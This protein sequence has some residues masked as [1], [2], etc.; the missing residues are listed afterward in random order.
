MPGAPAERTPSGQPPSGNIRQTG[1]VP[2][3]AAELTS[4]SRSATIPDQQVAPDGTIGVPYAGRI[5]AAGRTAEEVQKTIEAS[6][7]N[8]AL[9]PQALVIV[10]KS[11]ANSVTVAGDVVAG[12]RVPLS[13]AGD[14]L[15][16]VIAVAGAA[17]TSPATAAAGGI[18]IPPGT[19]AASGVTVSAGAAETGGAASAAALPAAI[20]GGNSITA[21]LYE[22]FVRLSRDGMT[23][24]I[25]VERLVAD[26]AENIYVR[27]GDVLYPGADTANL[28]RVRGYRQKCEDNI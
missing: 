7:A 23:A 27:P 18:T 20:V 3:A 17:T 15:L 8:K 21:P 11:D 9:G 22:I 10:K 25:P 4:E 12:A 5:P 19:A 6:L 28:R 16:Q 13:P 2:S 14:K 1:P 24:M 26:P